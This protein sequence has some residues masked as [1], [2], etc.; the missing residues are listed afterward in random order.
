MLFQLK[1]DELIDL[2]NHLHIEIRRSLKKTE[3]QKVVLQQLVNLHYLEE[4]YLGVDIDASKCSSVQDDSN[5]SLEVLRLK[6]KMENERNKRDYEVEK[7][8]L[9]LQ[10]LTSENSKK[11]SRKCKSF[12]TKVSL[13]IFALFLLLMKDTWTSF[14]FILKK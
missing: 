6:L 10:V 14:S 5:T 9:E 4:S 3:I 7:K 8:T 11:N 2:A 12:D 13:N 1:K